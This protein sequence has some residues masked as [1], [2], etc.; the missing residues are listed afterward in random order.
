MQE[1]AVI[2]DGDEGLLQRRRNRVERHVLPFVIEAEPAPAVG[3]VEPG[4][5]HA[6]SQLV[7]KERLTR[8]PDGDEDADDGNGREKDLRAASVRAERAEQTKGACPFFN[9]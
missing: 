2:F 3:R 6:A 4:I 8:Q 5:P 1:E 9:S 7:N